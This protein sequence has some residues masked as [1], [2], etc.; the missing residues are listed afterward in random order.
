MCFGITF[1]K[2]TAAESAGEHLIK[3]TKAKFV[4]KRKVR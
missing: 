3:D 1:R 2:P 4:G